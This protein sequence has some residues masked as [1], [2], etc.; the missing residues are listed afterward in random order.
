MKQCALKLGH[1]L[2][3]R[4]VNLTLDLAPYREGHKAQ[5]KQR[6]EDVEFKLLSIRMGGLHQYE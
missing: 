3:C 6:I 2:G 4:G 5:G 1:G